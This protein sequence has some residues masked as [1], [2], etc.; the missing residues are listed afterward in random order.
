MAQT[1]LV[2]FRATSKITVA[3]KSDATV[4]TDWMDLA[5]DIYNKIMGTVLTITTDTTADTLADEAI[6]WITCAVGYEE[7][8]PEK[9]DYTTKKMMRSVF[10]EQK[11]YSV[12]YSIDE[13]KIEYIEA[14]GIFIIRA[15]T[16]SNT[17]YMRSIGYDNTGDGTIIGDA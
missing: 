10:F 5:L 17:P 13:T 15:P 6:S 16:S 4:R 11:A 2:R 12:M 8:Y 3:D 14:D 7:L 1:I 9:M